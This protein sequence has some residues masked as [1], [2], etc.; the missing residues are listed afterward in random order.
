VRVGTTRIG[1]PAA[2]EFRRYY[3]AW[4]NACSTRDRDW[5]DRTIADDFRGIIFSPCSTGAA[6]AVIYDKPRYTDL[7]MLT[8]RPYVRMLTVSAVIE[9][10]LAAS[11]LLTFT[12]AT[13]STCADDALL[14]VMRDVS[15]V[16]RAYRVGMET[17]MTA[18]YSTTWRRAGS[19]WQCLS[20]Q[21]VGIVTAARASEAGG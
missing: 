8:V 20:H 15:S 16:P 19:G 1:T 21:A 6:R 3:E 17:G 11:T 14:R 10:K 9:G 18:L 4:T 7:Q 13:Y 12:Q 5:F 2:Y